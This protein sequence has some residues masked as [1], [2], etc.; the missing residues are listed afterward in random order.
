MNDNSASDSMTKAKYLRWNLSAESKK[1]INRIR[2]V[3][4]FLVLFILMMKMKGVP[5]QNIPFIERW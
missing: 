3:V 5:N 4:I 2:V 1:I